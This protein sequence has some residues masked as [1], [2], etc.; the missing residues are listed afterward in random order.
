MGQRLVFLDHE[1]FTPGLEEQV[2]NVFMPASPSIAP[3][4]PYVIFVVVDGVPGLGQ[5]VMVS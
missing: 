4:G 3:S 2:V 1:G 5:F